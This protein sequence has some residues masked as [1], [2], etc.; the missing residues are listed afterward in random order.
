M[1]LILRQVAPQVEVT[2]LADAEKRYTSGKPAKHARFALYTDAG[3]ILPCQ[4]STAMVSEA[5][6]LVRLTVVFTVDGDSVRVEG[7]GL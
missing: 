4:V 5:G 3:E 7:H 6:D 1:K 2:R